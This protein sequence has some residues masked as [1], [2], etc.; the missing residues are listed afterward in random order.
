ML[1]YTFERG[2]EKIDKREKSDEYDM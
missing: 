2:K 1:L